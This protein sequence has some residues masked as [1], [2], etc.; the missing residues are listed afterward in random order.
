[1]L[2]I[3]I[4]SF[5]IF[6][7]YLVLESILLTK[8]RESIP[9]RITITGIRGKTSV[10]RLLASVF[11]QDGKNVIAK[12]TGSKPYRIHRDGTE[13]VLKRW[14]LPSILEQKKLIKIAYKTKAEVLVSEIMSILP[15]NHFVESQKIL[16]PHIVALTNIRLDHT[17][18]MGETKENIAK[19]FCLD[20]PPK[21]TVFIPEKEKNTIILDSIK[22]KNCKYVEVKNKVSKLLFKNAQ[23]LPHHIFPEDLDIVYSICSY[24]NI[25]NP[26][27]IKGV[28]NITSDT[29]ALR[30]WEYKRNNKTLFLV[31]G[32]GAND[33]ESTLHTI[34]KIKKILPGSQEKITGLLCLRKDRGDRTLQWVKILKNNLNEIFSVLYI[35]GGHS[36]YVHRTLKAVKL[37]KAK[38]PLIITEK[39]VANLE[40]GSVFFGFGNFKGTGNRLI[41]YWKNIGKTYY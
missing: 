10:V 5:L 15:E 8:K 13:V 20:I 29:G 23:K 34:S 35:S 18:A 25:D 19:V 22:E 33:P 28:K 7:F 36:K 31:N 21:I 32:F 16:K 9:L 12:T 11:R 27:I 37:I 26:T 40:H 3:W 6:L 39:I 17:D 38:N 14:G 1:M 41:D 2:Y 30:I 24:L 4:L